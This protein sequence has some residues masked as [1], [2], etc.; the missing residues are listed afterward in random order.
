LVAYGIWGLV[1]LYFKQV[2]SVDPKELLA[3]RIVWSVLVLLVLLTIFKRWA[4]LRA[5]IRNRKTLLLLAISALLVMANWY[6]YILAIFTNRTIEASLGYFILPLANVAFGMLFFRERLRP[7]Q[8]LALA[9]AAFGLGR[10]IVS[11]NQVPWLAFF[12]TISFGL[13]GVLRKMA[14]VDGLI[15]F[16]IE[17]LLLLPMALGYLIWLAFEGTPRFLH[18]PSSLDF[19]IMFA[20]VVTTAPLI[21]FA[22]AVRKMGLITI[23]FIQ[24]VAPTTQ[25]LLAVFLFGEAFDKGKQISFGFIWF[26]LLIFVADTIIMLR[27][28]HR[29]DHLPSAIEA[30]E[31]D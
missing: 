27:R 1:P 8:A 5:T 31:V 20:G 11:Y 23:G 15:G 30:V 10:M 25:L 9:I 29:G 14:P 19:W 26:G 7:L 22:Q 16:T 21:C 12:L 6:G 28:A 13:Y 17:T 3:H 4:D 2:E 24:Y 18:P